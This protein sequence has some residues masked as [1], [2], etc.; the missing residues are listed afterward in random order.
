ML[1]GAYVDPHAR[2]REEENKEVK[3]V[4][5]VNKIPDGPQSKDLQA[6]F[7]Y[8]NPGEDEVD[9]EHVG[10]PAAVVAA[11]RV[12]RLEHQSAD[13]AE[14]HEKDQPVKA[15]VRND[16]KAPAPEG[17]LRGATPLPRLEHEHEP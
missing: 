16:S 14:Y 3:S 13:A 5:P 9:D 10:I 7:D 15:A 4:P 11:P 1:P 2:N 12:M 8:E 17:V 6:K